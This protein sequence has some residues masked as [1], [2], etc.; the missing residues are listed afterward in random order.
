MKYTFVLM[1][2]WDVPNFQIIFCWS[3]EVLWMA[4]Q[5]SASVLALVRAIEQPLP[6]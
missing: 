3:K 6:L 5:P 4:E 2:S 1:G